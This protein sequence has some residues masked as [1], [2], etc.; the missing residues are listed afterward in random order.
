MVYLVIR[1]IL[2]KITPVIIKMYKATDLPVI[3]YKIIV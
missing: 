3:I 1:E 2:A